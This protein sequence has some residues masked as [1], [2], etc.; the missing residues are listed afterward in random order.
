MTP[1]E[2]NSQ[3][4]TATNEHFES[5]VVARQEFK[6]GTS[7]TASE[8]RPLLSWTSRPSSRA[9]RSAGDTWTARSRA[10]WREGSGARSGKQVLAS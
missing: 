10:E 6:P 7:G 8:R 3:E 5:I 1:F 2:E 4:P 9:R